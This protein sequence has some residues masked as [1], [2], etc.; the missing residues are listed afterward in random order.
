MLRG[1]SLGEKPN[2]SMKTG[3]ECVDDSEI[4]LF[5]LF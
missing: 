3:L 4:S 2:D 1:L 5:A